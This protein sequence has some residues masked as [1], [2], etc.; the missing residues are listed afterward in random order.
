MTQQVKQLRWKHHDG[1]YPMWFASNVAIGFEARVDRGLAR[2]YGNYPLEI[3]GTIVKQKFNT[4]EA[5]Q[6]HAQADYVD[7]VNHIIRTALEPVDPA[8]RDK[9]V[10]DVLDMALYLHNCPVD[11]VGHYQDAANRLASFLGYPLAM[12]TS[13]SINERLSLHRAGL[14]DQT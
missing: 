1:N 13:M 11:R 14:H 3:N 10:E 5:A 2:M 6:A 4:L 7:R 9:V 8:A 12:N